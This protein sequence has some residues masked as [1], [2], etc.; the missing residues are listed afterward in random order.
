MLKTQACVREFMEKVGIP[1]LNED[2]PR[3]GNLRFDLLRELVREECGEYD[4]AM[5][6]LQDAVECGD[7][8]DETLAAWA[9]VVDAMCDIV[10]VVHNTANAM[11]IDL[12]PFFDEVHRT[13]LKKADGPVREDGKKLKPP[14]WEPPKIQEILEA[15]LARYEDE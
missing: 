14:D 10:V 6:R 2:R 4:R 8:A 3:V 15:V 5:V 11:G 9:E 13:N 7:M 12:E 1:L